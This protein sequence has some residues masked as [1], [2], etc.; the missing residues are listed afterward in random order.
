M[1]QPGRSLEALIPGQASKSGQ[2]A[3]GASEP[4]GLRE[5]GATAR[6]SSEQRLVCSWERL[7]G[8]Q[9]LGLIPRTFEEKL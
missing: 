2:W 7:G 5:D 1:G 9:S 4:S 3:S 6:L 8:K